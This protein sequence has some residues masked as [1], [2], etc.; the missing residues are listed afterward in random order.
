MPSLSITHMH[1]SY[2]VPALLPSTIASCWPAAPPHHRRL[3][4]EGKGKG[5]TASLL[6]VAPRR[7]SAIN[8]GHSG[9]SLS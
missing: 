9:G 5:A 4:A 7:Y 6:F 8:G 1:P 3:I 2:H